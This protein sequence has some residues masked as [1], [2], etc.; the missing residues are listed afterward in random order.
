MDN[1]LIEGRLCEKGLLKERY[2]ESVQ[3][4]VRTIT[5]K[6]KKVV[7]NLLKKNP[8]ARKMFIHIMRDT[9]RRIPPR[10]HKDFMVELNKQ[11]K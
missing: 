7:K 6:G 9:M 8:I 4:L 5:P 3:D 10:L 2:E 11:L 1:E